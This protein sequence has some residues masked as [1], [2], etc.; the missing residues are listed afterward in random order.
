MDTIIATP[1]LLKQANLSLI[2]K[3]IKARTTATKAEI[4]NDTNIST[5]TIRSLLSEMQQNG[6]IESV[7]LDKSSGGRKAERY[8][9]KLDRYYGAAFCITD[10]QAYGLL[11]DVY[12]K[13]METTKLEV[14]DEDYETAICAFLDAL[15]LEKDIKSIGIGVPGIV[16]N[17]SYWI[18]D[19]Q[20]ELCKIDIGKTLELKYH[21]PVFLENDLNAT[22]IGFGRCY[23]KEFPN[24]APENTNM[25]YL[26]FEYD[27]ISAGFI[28]EGRVIRGCN[29]F[30][31]ELGLI[32][33]NN[34][35]HLYE[36]F[37]EP[38]GDIE[39]TNLA[40]HI[41]CWIC[42]ILNPQYVALGGPALRKDLIGPIGDGL[43]TLLPKH[44][45]PEI[46]YAPDVW[47]DYFDGLA[48][49]TAG[50]IFHDVQFIKE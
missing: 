30:A 24:E 40:I 38:I 18:Q 33:M 2:R 16:E 19:K 43:S 36:C 49:L 10:K 37:A 15:L 7:G 50:K 22:A 13:I 47:H 29:N 20:G 44:M 31:G 4:V 5:T 25:V 12:G 23:R 26:Y 34:G 41:I 35:K 21:I 28:S 27:C 42:G 9:F 48:Y 45:L 39:Y 11:V 8:Q 32:P 17:G 3:A 1:N 46:L 6:E 14:T